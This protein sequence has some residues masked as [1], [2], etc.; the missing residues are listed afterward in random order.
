MRT[1]RREE[2]SGGTR[3]RGGRGR[4]TPGPLAPLFICLSL[5]PGLPYVNWA[6]QECCLS[7][8]RSSLRAS[9]LPLF[10]FL[11]FS[12]SCLL[13]TAILDSCFLFYLHNSFMSDKD[14][15]VFQIKKKIY[16]ASCAESLLIVLLRSSVSWLF[17]VCLLFGLVLSVVEREVLKFPTVIG[18]VY[19]SL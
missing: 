15:L 19:F 10:C 3:A 1:Q 2:K 12:L 14:R 8:L 7:Y 11:G 5:P 6:S 4:E 9:D 16:L 17:F 18:I 13:A